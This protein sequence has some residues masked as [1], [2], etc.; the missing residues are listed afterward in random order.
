MLIFT[1]L[2]LIVLGAV[3]GSAG[4]RRLGRW[5]GKASGR[6]R[7]GTGVSAL[8]LAFAGLAFT[9][10]GLLPMGLALLAS[11]AI[12]AVTARRRP[13]VAGAGKPKV[14]EPPQMSEAEARSVL[15]VPPNATRKEVQEAYLRLMQLAHPDHGGTSGLAA[16]L[17]AAR[18]RLLG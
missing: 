13:S 14:A 11:A 12:L 2:A 17:N 10:R 3:F 4:M 16:Q 7:S 18:K 5:A 8:I 15:G 6:W 9:V 1:V